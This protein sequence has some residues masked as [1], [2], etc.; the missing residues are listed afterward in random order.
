MR[1]HRTG[2]RS[3]H[4]RTEANSP[5]PDTLNYLPGNYR[6]QRHG[7]TR[8]PRARTAPTRPLTG[9][10]TEVLALLTGELQSPRIIATALDRTASGVT[11]SLYQLEA[12]GLAER[13]PAK[14]WRLK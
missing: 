10:Q 6:I 8:S 2:R 1:R 9:A 5:N 11:A 3:Q 4:P 13:V 7:I 12:R 14:G